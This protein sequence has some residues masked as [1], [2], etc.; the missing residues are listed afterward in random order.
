MAGL[1]AF[2]P[3]HLVQELAR[4]RA[5]TAR[6]FPGALLVADVSGFTALTERLQR[7]GRDGAETGAARVDAAFRPAIAAIE[8]RGGSLVGFGGDALLALY[9]GRSAVRAALASAEE[10]RDA[11][12]RRAAAGEPP[13]RIR[14][15]IHHGALRELHLGTARRRHC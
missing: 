15:A 6:S 7:R 2:L 4:G 8:H 5:R 3:P 14:Q 11:A 12:Q 10:I 13:L 1:A 9:T